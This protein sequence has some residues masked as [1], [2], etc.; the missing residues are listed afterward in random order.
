VNQAG[1]LNRRLTFLTGARV[2]DGQGGYF[3]N[4]YTAIG[5]VPNVWAS[6]RPLRGAELVAAQ[7]MHADARY[8]VTT[9][10]RSDLSATYACSF[11]DGTSTVY[12]A[13]VSIMPLH[14]D[15][16]LLM[17]CRSVRADELGL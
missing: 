11:L 8:R 7:Q 9:R 4:A 14:M 5:T 3:E 16:V 1:L 10:W 6:V 13:V 2:A 12:L 15:G 17:D